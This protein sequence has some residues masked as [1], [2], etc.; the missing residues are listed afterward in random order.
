MATPIQVVLHQDV[1]NLGGSGDVVRVRPGFARNFLFPRGLAVRATKGS[2]KRIG[3]LKRAA[4]VRAEKLREDAIERKKQVEAV[5]VKIERAV[6]AGNK[7]Y[8]SVT[9]K[10]IE[11]AFAALDITLDRRKMKLAEPIK[12]LGLS[13]VEVKLFEDVTATLRVEVVIQ[14]S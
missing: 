8:G 6:G 5:A 1:D 7:M 4:A 14:T 9:T 2:L 12:A 3:E 10:D 13:E 11:E